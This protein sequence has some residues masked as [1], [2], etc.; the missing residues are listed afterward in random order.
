MQ[1][2][3]NWLNVRAERIVMSEA[4]S[5]WQPL[6]KMVGHLCIL[7]NKKKKVQKIFFIQQFLEHS[8]FSWI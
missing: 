4:V 2:V 8:P 5:G 3:K 6:K 7:I 1:W